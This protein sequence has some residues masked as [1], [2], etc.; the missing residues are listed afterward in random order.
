[1][2]KFDHLWDQGELELSWMIGILQEGVHDAQNK[3]KKTF[4]VVDDC[5]RGLNKL[6]YLTLRNR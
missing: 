3:K 5:L 6:N 2:T 4:S 1:M